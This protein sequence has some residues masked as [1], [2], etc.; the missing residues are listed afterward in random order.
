L[1]PTYVR[2][3]QLLGRQYLNARE[4]ARADSMA[5]IIERLPQGLSAPERL[6]LDYHRAELNGDIPGMLKAQQKP[7]AIDSNPLALQLYGEAAIFMLRP[8]WAIPAIERAQP[9]FLLMGGGA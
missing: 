2:A 9:A 1:D 6:Q 3:Y 7:A 5:N 4:F 8:D